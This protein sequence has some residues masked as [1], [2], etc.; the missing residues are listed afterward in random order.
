MNRRATGMQRRI[1]VVLV[2]A[3]ILGVALVGYETRLGSPT[4]A[5][6]SASGAVSATMSG[7]SSALSSVSAQ[8]SSSSGATPELVQ[9]GFAE[10]GNLPYPLHVATP[11]AVINYTVNI[12]RYDPTVENASVAALSSV[13]GVR[14]I[15]VP[16]EFTFF[17]SEEAVTLDVSVAPNV[18]ASGFQL[19][20]IANTS[21]GVNSIAFPFT[22]DNGLVVV[23]VG[24]NGAFTPRLLNVHVGQPVTFFD[25][26][27]IDD[28]GNGYVNVTIPSIPVSSPRLGP[29]EIWTHAF[30]QPGDYT[31][32]VAVLGGVQ[33]SGI[34][35]VS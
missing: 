27:G 22:I 34:I 2:A 24:S 11:N 25:F 6:T 35:R 12:L 14:A 31:F 29:N 13:S 18:T 28:D 9:F 17:G 20:F 3:V 30:S 33:A 23:Q 5:T 16:S 26:I 19:T 8:S 1:A 4:P 7:S 32:E 10:I 15:F 21:K